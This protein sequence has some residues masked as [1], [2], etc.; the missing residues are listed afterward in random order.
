M[1][2]GEFWSD[3]WVGEVSFKSRFNRLYMIS[4]QKEC[5]VS[6]CGFW[7]TNG[8]VWNLKWSRVLR[9]RDESFLNELMEYLNRVQI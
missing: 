7:G 5:R 6:E 4:V 3:W 9:V 1:G 8:W 2:N